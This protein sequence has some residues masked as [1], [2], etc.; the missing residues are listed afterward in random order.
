[1]T[2]MSSYT[3]AS[4][5]LTLE[6]VFKNHARRLVLHMEDMKRMVLSFMISDIH[7]IPT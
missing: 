5:L 1:M 4:P 6:Q 7:I 3:E 2:T